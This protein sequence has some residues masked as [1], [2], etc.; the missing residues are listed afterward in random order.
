M[1]A[2]PVSQ[3]AVDAAFLSDLERGEFVEARILKPGA[4]RLHRSGGTGMKSFDEGLADYCGGTEEFRSRM[5]V[6][7]ADNE[8]GGLL[9]SVGS[10]EFTPVSFTDARNSVSL[11]QLVM[12]TGPAEPEEKPL[13]AEEPE[14]KQTFLQRLLALFGL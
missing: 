14:E 12:M 4:G 3:V 7:G 5:S 11:V 6:L 13:P 2:I 9:R 8:I 1:T 10:S